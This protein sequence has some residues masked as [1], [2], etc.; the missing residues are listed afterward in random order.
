MASACATRSVFF[1]SD[2]ADALFSPFVPTSFP[3]GRADAGEDAAFFDAA[4]FFCTAEG[5]GHSPVSAMARKD[6]AI[7][8]TP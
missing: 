1:P 4:A 6:A 3:L 8:R 2:G 5:S 7:L